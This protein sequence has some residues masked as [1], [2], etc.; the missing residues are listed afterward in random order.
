MLSAT[1]ARAL[2]QG[3]MWKE[4]ARQ[5]EEYV[6]KRI[7]E[8]CQNGRSSVYIMFDKNITEYAIATVQE[9]LTNNGYTH[10]RVTNHFCVKW[11]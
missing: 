11:R 10:N 4:E 5:L 6:S 8:A 7:R 2:T 9:I 3:D 1:E